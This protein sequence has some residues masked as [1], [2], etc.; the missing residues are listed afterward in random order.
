MES[1][2]KYLSFRNLL[3][4]AM[5]IL[6]LSTV[7]VWNTLEHSTAILYKWKLRMM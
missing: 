6:E 7:T 2:C 3:G 5:F 1:I 4:H